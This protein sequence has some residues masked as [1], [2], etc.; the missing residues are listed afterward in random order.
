MADDNTIEAEALAQ[1][2]KP[3]VGEKSSKESRDLPARHR[4]ITSCL[5]FLPPGCN[6][7]IRGTDL[8][9]HLRA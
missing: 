6:I 8:L 3:A 9:Y 1:K 5:R 7:D 4:V 2:Q